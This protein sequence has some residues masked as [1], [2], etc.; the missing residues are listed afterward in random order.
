PLSAA[1]GAQWRRRLPTLLGGDSAIELS[2]L[3]LRTGYLISHAHRRLREWAEERLSPLGLHPRDFGVL[4]ILDS[5]APC[6]QNH[7]ASR[8]GIS[9]PAALGFVDG[10]E[11]RGLVVRHRREDDR[12]AYDLTLTDDGR[13]TLG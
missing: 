7:L 13:A 6:S 11:A 4:S 1:E 5:D 9:P 10:L 2:T 8:L 3:S 12:R